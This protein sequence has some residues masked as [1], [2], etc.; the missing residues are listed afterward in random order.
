MKYKLANTRT[1][2][3]TA[4]PEDTRSKVVQSERKNCDINNIVA[5]AKQTGQLPV[6]MGREP[7]VNLPT[8]QTYQE[9]L[10]TVVKATQAFERLP[11]GIRNQFQNKPENMLAAIE[12]GKTDKKIAENLREIGL[13]APLPEKPPEAKPQPKT[14]T[15][16]GAPEPN[17]APPTPSK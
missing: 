11:S 3:Q 12:A 2:I 9:M 1:R 8:Q 7:I 5:R 15:P 14:G 13:L 17:G 10:N 4:I 6:L 16:E